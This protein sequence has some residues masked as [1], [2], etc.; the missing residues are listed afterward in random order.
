MVGVILSLALFFAEHVLWPAGFGG[1][2]EWLAAVIGAGALVAL[3][4]Y[5]AGVIPVIGV[6]AGLGLLHG[7]AG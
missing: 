4:R 2:F 6:C 7:L 5:K 3:I 1:R